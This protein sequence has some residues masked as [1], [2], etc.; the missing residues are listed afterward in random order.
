MKDAF[1]FAIGIASSIIPQGLPAEINTALAQ[2]ASKLA[3]ARA[4]VKKL[5]AVETLGAT[6][7]ILTDKT[8]TLTKNEMTV[9][10]LLVGK[11]EY[12]VSGTGYEANGVVTNS[13]GKAIPGEKIKKDSRRRTSEKR[14]FNPA[15]AQHVPAVQAPASSK[16][17]SAGS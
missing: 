4:L 3:R 16:R 9:E 12:G 8:G 15:W 13:G 6:N 10:Q 14:L 11:T 1:L 17:S 5:S 7:I 2:A